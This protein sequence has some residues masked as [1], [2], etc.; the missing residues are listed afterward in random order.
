[1]KAKLSRITQHQKNKAIDRH[2]QEMQVF[3]FIMGRD[4]V[5]LVKRAKHKPP[6]MQVR[7]ECYTKNH[8]SLII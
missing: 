3:S 7:D 8:L 4:P 1:M 6:A 5:E 2:L